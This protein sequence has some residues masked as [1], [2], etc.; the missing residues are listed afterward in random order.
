MEEKNLKINDP[1]QLQQMII[2]LKAEIAKYKDEI[3]KYKESDY[4]SLAERFEQENIQLTKEKND[5]S[6]QV[7]KLAEELKSRTS[8][9]EKRIRSQQ[10]QI[11][12]YISSLD[13]L[14]KTKVELQ[15]M[16]EQLTLV[17]NELNDSLQQQIE[18]NKTTL[19]QLEN[20]LVHL[21]QD[22]MK[23]LS[24]QM[25]K[26]DLTNK[27]LLQ[28]EKVKQHLLNEIEEKNNII[29]KLEIEVTDL[30][31]RNEQLA[32]DLSVVEKSLEKER[33]E[34]GRLSSTAT[35][36]I[37]IET[38][39]ELEREINEILE[40]SLN[41]KEKMEAKILTIDTLEYKL[42]ELIKEMDSV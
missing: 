18:F 38:L 17:M 13:T 15:E 9:Y 28:S 42:N 6:E 33:A 4:Y 19:G 24:S 39:M 12:E 37:D 8:N 1:L 7:V 5:L 29:S 32:E 27:E 11:R 30:K 3:N 21:I 40:Q 2:F 36:T 34:N 41:Y 16:N 20:K 25:K 14:Q 35:P 10:I 23:L 26:V 22:S 31:A